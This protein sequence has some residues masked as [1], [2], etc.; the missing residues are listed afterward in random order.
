M[1]QRLINK[2]V[3]IYWNLHRD[4]FS[5]RE[6]G[7]KVIA[8]AHFIKL[9]DC[10]FRVSQAGRKR[11]LQ[12]RTKNVHAGVVGYVEEI[13]LEPKK[14]KNRQ[15]IAYYNPFKTKG[16][17]DKKSKEPICFSKNVT[18]GVRNGRPQVSYRKSA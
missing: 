5:V 7:G 8:H 1:A 12:N 6:W 16:F 17:I 13:S 3:F 10:E 9:R 14:F 15:N 18:M 4:L 2:K 11:V